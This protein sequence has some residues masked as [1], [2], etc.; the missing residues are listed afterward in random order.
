MIRPVWVRVALPDGALRPL[1][2]RLDR[3]TEG[4][5]HEVRL[6]P[7]L[8]RVG[9]P[10]A[11]ALAGPVRDPDEP[12]QGA[13]AVYSVLPGR[14]LLQLIYDAPKSEKPALAD[15]LLDA[16]AR[17]QE[18]TPR[19][20]AL[21][22]R[23]HLGDPLPRRGLPYELRAATESGAAHRRPE[24]DRATELLAPLVARVQE[25]LCFWNG[26]FNPANFLSDG[27]QLTGF[28]DFAHASWHDPHY[29]LARFTV[30]HWVHLDRAL[31]FQRYRERHHLSERDFALRSAVHCL[32]MLH[33]SV[34]GEP[35][36]DAYRARILAQLDA[37]LRR[38]TA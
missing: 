31:L 6:L 12:D 37:D 15:L 7:L 33:T 16:I 17:L 30:Y 23:E 11:E 27:R 22:E 18:L 29:G 28:V 35:V 14:N 20:R 1:I 9:L 26:D 5:D 24:L 13:M 36:D 25:P 4:V 21:L 8:A 32:W 34:P 19:L 38:L 3:S 2:L 10:V